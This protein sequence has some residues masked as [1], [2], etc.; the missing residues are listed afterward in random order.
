MEEVNQNSIQEVVP[1]TENHENQD[2]SP[3][4]AAVVDN[5]NDR[6]WKAAMEKKREL[7]R[8][9]KMQRDMNE[10]LLATF[11]QPKTPQEVDELD[12]IAE[13][14]Y[15]DKGKN[16]RLV[17]KELQ[18]LQQKIAELE[19]KLSMQTN[20]NQLK[21]QFADYDEVVT[22]ET[23]LLLEE[24]EPELVDTIVGSKDPYK[25]GVQAYKYIKAMNLSSKVPDARR[26]K[27]VERKIE[28]NA[29]T[30]PSPLANDKRPMAQAFRLT[31]QEKSAL[32]N[33]MI[34]FASQASMAPP[35]QYN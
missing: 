5:R 9:L 30:I 20:M 6:N 3:Q 21:R 29:N 11:Q 31:E 16:K 33:E 25:I 27:E 22:P 35:I 17:K 12:A 1:Q 13:N 18:P 23:M 34:G 2:S 28:K 14:E 7:E 10:R 8:E 26:A 32:Y 19:H 15:L 24:Q 4:V